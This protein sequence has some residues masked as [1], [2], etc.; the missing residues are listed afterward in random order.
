MQGRE[1]WQLNPCASVPCLGSWG[2]QG[3][4]KGQ[5]P[6]QQGREPWLQHL[7]RLPLALWSLGLGGWARREE[8]SVA[9]AA[10]HRR[11]QACPSRRDGVLNLGS[12]PELLA[13]SCPPPASLRV[14]DL[15]VLMANP[16]LVGP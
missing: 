1:H 13:H 6:C 11:P 15:R 12:V 4:P 9:L 7:E 3:W 2:T 16:D 5:D 10:A 8:G 14:P